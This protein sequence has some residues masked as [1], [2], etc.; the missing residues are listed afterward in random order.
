MPPAPK[1]SGGTTRERGFSSIELL[2][3]ELMDR[4]KPVSISPSSRAT[5]RGP[6]HSL[7]SWPSAKRSALATASSSLSQNSGSKPIKCPSNPDRKHPVLYHPKG[8]YY[9]MERQKATRALHRAAFCEN[10]PH[11]PPRD[12]LPRE[13]S[14]RTTE[15]V[16]PAEDLPTESA[17]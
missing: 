17:K 7:T 1:C 16:Q 14:V 5:R 2:K 3:S 15:P 10:F 9:S 6:H 13:H 11:G 12:F 8:P 4:R